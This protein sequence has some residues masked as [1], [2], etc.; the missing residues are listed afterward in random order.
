VEQVVR[1]EAAGEIFSFSAEAHSNFV[2]ET[3]QEFS[4]IY[5]ISNSTTIENKVEMKTNLKEYFLTDGKA[6]PANF[7]LTLLNPKSEVKTTIVAAQNN[8]AKVNVSA[9]TEVSPKGIKSSASVGISAEKGRVKVEANVEGSKS[10]DNKGNSKSS[11]KIG[12]DA[13][14]KLK[15][16]KRDNTKVSTSLKVG[17]SI[18]KDF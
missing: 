5:S 17:G 9:K 12:A 1:A 3:K 10:I 6:N 2:I 14:L 8:V 4:P 7:N 13:S 18:S 16:T 15:E 11:V